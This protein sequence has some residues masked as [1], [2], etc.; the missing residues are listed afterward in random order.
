MTASDSDLL[1]SDDVTIAVNNENSNT[2]NPDNN[3]PV[4]DNNPT[5]STS[6]GGGGCFIA[7][8]AYGSLLEPHVKILRDFRDRLLTPN[9]IGKSFVNLY[10]KYSPPF[11]NFIAKHHNLRI[12][13]RMALL[14]IVGIS[15]VALKLGILITISLIFLFGV[16]LMGLMKIKKYKT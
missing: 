15:W 1:S 12:I 3:T 2:S 5:V 14:P 16:G 8:A 6:G 13:V 7:T 10:Y 9:A 11:A 4:S